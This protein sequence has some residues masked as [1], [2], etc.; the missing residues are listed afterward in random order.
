MQ[1]P[2]NQAPSSKP[3]SSGLAMAHLDGTVRPQDDLYRFANGVW[4]AETSIPDDRVAVT[5]FTVVAD[6]VQEQLFQL[7]THV[8]QRPAAASAP[9]SDRISC[10][11]ASFM[12]ETAIEACGLSPLGDWFDSIDAI[13]TTMDV[14]RWVARANVIVGNSPL[15]ITVDIDRRDSSVYRATLGQGTLGLPTR[16]H[17]L[18]TACERSAT[19]RRQYRDHAETLF[20]ASGISSDGAARMAQTVLAVETAIARFQWS[21]I[22]LRDVERTY[23]LYSLASLH[24]LAPDFCW[25]LFF[26]E[27]A[28]QPGDG[29]VVVAQPDYV[30]ALTQWMIE[31]PLSDLKTYF[32]WL[33]LSTYAPFLRSAM[34]EQSLAFHRGVLRGVR[35]LPPRW[36]RAVDCV[37][38][39]LADDVGQAYVDAFFPATYQSRIDALVRNILQ[40]CREKIA[41]NGFYD[42]AARQEALRKLANL[43]VKIGAPVSRE[44]RHASVTLRA[45]DL[46]GNIAALKVAAYDNAIKK[47]SSPVDTGAWPMSPQ[48]VNACYRPDRNEVVFPAAIL[49]APFFSAER[50]DAVNYGAIGA[51]IG[52]EISHAFD[53]QGSRYDSEGILRNWWSDND[54]RRFSSLMD[55]FVDQYGSYAAVDGEK[56]DGLLTLGEN[57]ADNAGL[58]IA[59][60]AYML[61]L[62]GHAVRENTVPLKTARAITAGATTAPIIDGLTGEQRFFLSFA[63]MWATKMRPEAVAAY[64]KMDVHA[65]PHVRANG[66]LRNHPGFYTAFNVRPG[67][68]LYLAPEHRLTFW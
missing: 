16:D 48:E 13:S 24:E 21:P 17:Y 66:A 61:S 39:F 31:T 45:D 30:V 3:G 11:Y 19:L 41:R 10:L 9:A 51:V 64:S 60:A 12:D 4:L 5:S 68:A 29:D 67:D 54:R 34:A 36:Q 33:V 7:V 37:S 32:K 62:D 44:S 8:T 46:V 38:R 26:Q 59:H 23:Q 65:P 1:K 40:A 52:H 18:A 55:R 25:R 14:A 35:A 63:Q 47:L 28:L 20:L 50:D 57:I 2:F 6:R 56:V 49:Q 22:A 43:S 27:S 15:R 53:D 58:S 42:E